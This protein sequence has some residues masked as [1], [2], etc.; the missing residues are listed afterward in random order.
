MLLPADL[1]HSGLLFFLSNLVLVAFLALIILIL[2]VSIIVKIATAAAS[3]IPVGVKA[4]RRHSVES[5]GRRT[6]RV[7]RFRPLKM[8]LGLGVAAYAIVMKRLQAGS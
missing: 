3:E 5:V 8:V 7:T 6:N 1:S 4:S 2:A